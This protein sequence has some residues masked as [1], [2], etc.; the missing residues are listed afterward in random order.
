MEAVSCAY[1]N[2]HYEEL[3]SF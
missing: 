3:T 1:C 2:H